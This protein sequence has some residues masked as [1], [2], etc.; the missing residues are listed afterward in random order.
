[1]I[2]CGDSFTKDGILSIS[3]YTKDDLRIR[4]QSNHSDLL[5]FRYTHKEKLDAVQRTLQGDRH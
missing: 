2:F 4:E 1:M 3:A 5:P